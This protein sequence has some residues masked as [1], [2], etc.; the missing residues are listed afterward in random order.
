VRED[1]GSPGVSLDAG[2]T[3]ASGFRRARE[4]PFLLVDADR[5][6]RI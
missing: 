3:R 6:E 2:R 4:G 1:R 5:L